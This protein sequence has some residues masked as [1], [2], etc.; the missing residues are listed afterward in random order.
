MDRALHPVIAKARV[1]FPVKPEFFRFFFWLLGSSF[2]RQDH[3]L[4]HIILDSYD[5]IRLKKKKCAENR[6]TVI[7]FSEFANV[8]RKI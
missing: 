5:L 1:R 7:N 4:F 3:V 2:N 8:K 6:T